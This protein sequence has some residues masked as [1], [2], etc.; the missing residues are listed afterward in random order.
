MPLAHP[1]NAFPLAAGL[2]PTG[3][4]SLSVYGRQKKKKPE[5]CH[6][7]L[8]WPI[9]RKRSAAE[10]SVETLPNEKGGGAAAVEATG[11]YQV[12]TD[13]LTNLRRD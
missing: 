5:V 2:L 3:T 7:R 11:R 9:D 1:G 8:I 6:H 4:G 13:V 10:R 12:R